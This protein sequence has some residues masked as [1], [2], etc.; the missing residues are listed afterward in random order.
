MKH[1]TEIY[2]NNFSD[3]LLSD[4]YLKVTK[5]RKFILNILE[6]DRN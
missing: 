3:A 4:D 1:Q 6:N 5:Y 2:L